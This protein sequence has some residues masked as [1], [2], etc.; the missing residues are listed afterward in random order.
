MKSKLLMT[1]AWVLGFVISI[2][3]VL[4]FT[5]EYTAVTWITIIFTGLAF[6]T[7][8]LLW[9]GFTKAEDDTQK[10]FF[11][12]PIMVVSAFYLLLQFV[13]CCVIAL[14]TKYISVRI[15]LFLNL[16]LFLTMWLIIILIIV[17]KK[18]IEKVD[19]RQKNNHKEL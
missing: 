7:Q 10:E 4:F 12:Y 16:L 13:I 2:V 8:F 5:K 15:G 6:L 9:N 19:K 1:I 18:Q 3:I 11:S 14:A 17:S